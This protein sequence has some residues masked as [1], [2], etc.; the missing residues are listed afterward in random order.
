LVILFL[1]LYTYTLIYIFFYYYTLFMSDT[2]AP[3]ATEPLAATPLA[4]APLAT[5][6]PATEP[7]AA[8][9][10]AATLPATA[11]LATEPP[12][13]EPP[14]TEPLATA[15]PSGVAQLVVAFKDAENKS[16]PPEAQCQQIVDAVKCLIKKGY[17]RVGLAYSANQKPQTQAMFREYNYDPTLSTNDFNIGIPK[18]ISDVKISGSNQAA[19]LMKLDSLTDNEFRKVF[20]IIPFNRFSKFN[21]LVLKYLKFIDQSSNFY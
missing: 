5:E 20:R 8:T 21:I 18:T 12:A 11:P 2:T 10:P 9:L 16:I 4:T 7:P 15:L 17:K 13:T 1:F 6:P 19:T 3:P 14:A